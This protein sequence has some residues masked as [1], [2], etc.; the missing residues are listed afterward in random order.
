M[1]LRSMKPSRISVRSRATLGDS[2]DFRDSMGV[3]QVAPNCPIPSIS[4]ARMAYE[5]CHPPQGATSAT[6]N[7]SYVVF[8]VDGDM[9]EKYIDIVES[10]EASYVR[11]VV[12]SDPGFRFHIG[13]FTIFIT[14]TKP[15][16]P[17][18]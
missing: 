7:P 1:M 11:S 5:L 12:E 13:P 15:V 4:Q 10:F 6:T 14:K 18:Q 17:S 9:V 2:R 8:G 16:E 3:F